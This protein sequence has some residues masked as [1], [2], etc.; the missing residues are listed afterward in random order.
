MQKLKKILIYNRFEVWNWAVGRDGFVANKCP[1]DTCT[2]VGM[3]NA[4]EADAVL[5]NNVFPVNAT[6]WHRPS[7]QV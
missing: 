7:N 2:M 5:F 4:S 6:P 1:V 3:K